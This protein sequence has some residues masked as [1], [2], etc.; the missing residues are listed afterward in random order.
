M[1]R[2]PI[3]MLDT[4]LIDRDTTVFWF[5]RDLRLEDNAGLYRAL[6]EHDNVL[7]I[8]IFDTE[9]LN[10]LED[11]SDRR[12]DFIHQAL[13]HLKG[14]LESLGSSLYI[15]HDNPVSFFERIQPKNVFTNLDYEPY[16][17]GRD[18][19]VRNILEAKGCKL[20]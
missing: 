14:Q 3:S 16:A 12:V 13:A 6:K 7:P 20:I 2:S 10:K 18:K 4:D 11:R 8:F 17:R 19:T 15:V 9:I 1:T 5:R